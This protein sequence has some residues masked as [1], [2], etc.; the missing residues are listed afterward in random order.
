VSTLAEVPS[1]AK[2]ESHRWHGDIKP[3]NILR[4]RGEF[5]LADFGFTKFEKD[6]IGKT[7]TLI[8][9]GT[10]TY[11]KSKPLDTC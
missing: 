3:D 9:G 6:E 8:L 10:Q 1:L 4:V 11:G 5:K 2:L 7:S